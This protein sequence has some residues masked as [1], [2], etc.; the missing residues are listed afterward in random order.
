M[1]SRAL[2]AK[3]RKSFKYGYDYSKSVSINDYEDCFVGIME[4]LPLIHCDHHGNNKSGVLYGRDSTTGA[5][6]HHLTLREVMRGSVGVI[7]ES[8]YGITEKVVL[9]D[10]KV[11]SLKRFRKVIVKRSEFGRR[12]ERLAQ[13]SDK[14]N[15]LVPVTAHLYAK[16]I[17]FLLCD[18]YPMGTLSDLLAGGR[19]Y[20]HTALDWTQRLKIVIHVSRAIAYIHAQS[21]PQEKNMRMNVHGNIKTSNVMV[22]TDFSACLSDYGVAQLAEREEVSNT[23]VYLEDLCQKCDIY[24]FGVI[25][26]DIL[27]GPKAL[28]LANYNCMAKCITE[29]KEKI[30]DGSIDFFELPLSEG[31]ERMQALLVLDI[32]LFCINTKPEARP[33]MEH[34]VSYLGDVCSKE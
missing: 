14:C 2:T 22:N 1:I 13:V 33:S 8:R 25:L 10:G 17:K 11:C 15:Y 29:N 26:L 23:K 9:L 21:P 19:E 18:Y 24:N 12:I 32:A 3:S 16:R 31:I 28:V 6:P 34:I 7:G 30:K 27:A 4:D 5:Q 20:G